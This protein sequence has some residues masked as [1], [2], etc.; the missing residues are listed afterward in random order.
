MF[1]KLFHIP[2]LRY[3]LRL[4]NESLYT[5]LTERLARSSQQPMWLHLSKLQKHVVFLF[6]FSC[7]NNTLDTTV[8]ILDHSSDN[9]R[10]RKT[11]IKLHPYKQ[12]KLF[13]QAGEQTPIQQHNYTN[14]L[15]E[16]LGSWICFFK[17]HS[18]KYV[19]FHNYT[20]QS[21]ETQIR[22]LASRSTCEP[23]ITDFWRRRPPLGE[24]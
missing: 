10:R 1:C 6:P 15:P 21:D 7:R 13:I 16:Q 23:W 5:F 24:F 17:G 8:H 12:S 22:L 19:P 3:L 14:S 2:H 11:S 4:C 18:K 20:P 9:R